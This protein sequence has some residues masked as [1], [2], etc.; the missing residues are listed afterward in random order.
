MSKQ[1]CRGLALAGGLSLLLPG[2]ARH[3]NREQTT[4]HFSRQPS[5]VKPS[6]ANPSVNSSSFA[7]DSQSADAGT[8]APERPSPFPAALASEPAAARTPARTQPAG[9]RESKSNAKAATKPFI[10]PAATAAS[11][12]S[13]IV[14][15]TPPPP[16]IKPPTPD[17]SQF[18]PFL[19]T[20]CCAATATYEPVKPNSFRRVIQKVPVLRRLDPSSTG[21]QGFAPPQPLHD[22]RFALPP[23]A[24]PMLMRK[25]QM[26]LKASVDASGRVTRVQLLSPRDE[27]L[28]TRAADA[29]N[30]WRFAPAQ[31]NGHPVPGEVILHFSFDDSPAAQA[32]MDSS[33][34][35]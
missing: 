26:D 9:S 35:R 33:K 3:E 1:L 34:V 31:L 4:S 22:I 7:A 27:D 8:V 12:M 29:A 13:N 15:S 2:C 25:K 6:V 11:P 10:M 18:P 19:K 24:I 20:M 23:D 16:A 14:A 5:Q 21:G 32:A 17:A 28:V 30:A